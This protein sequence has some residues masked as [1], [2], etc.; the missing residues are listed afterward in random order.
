MTDTD[1]VDGEG[2]PLRV[3]RRSDGERDPRVGRVRPVGV[4][5]RQTEH[6]QSWPAVLRHAD[7]YDVSGH[8]REARTAVV[9]VQ[10]FDH[11]LSLGRQRRTSG[12]LFRITTAL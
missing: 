5:R 11:Q 6:G 4:R 12:V 8:R 10:N 3:G 9:L 2:G 7:R 1:R